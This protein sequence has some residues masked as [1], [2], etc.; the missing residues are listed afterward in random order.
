MV[1]NTPGNVN[2]DPKIMASLKESTIK[3]VVEANYENV[4]KRLEWLMYDKS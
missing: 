2:N 1:L 3:A 4:K